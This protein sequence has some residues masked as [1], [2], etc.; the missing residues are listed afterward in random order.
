MASTST[1]QRQT[2]QHTLEPSSTQMPA[3]Q[4]GCLWAL[5]P[6]ACHQQNRYRQQKQVVPRL[7]TTECFRCG[8]LAFT[9]FVVE[10]T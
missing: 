3:A 2:P 8:V 5:K 9:L 4:P 7:Q 6:T 1:P 10:C